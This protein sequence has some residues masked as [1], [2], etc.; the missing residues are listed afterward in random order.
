MLILHAMECFSLEK[1]LI[2]VH[3]SLKNPSD[4]IWLFKNFFQHKMLVVA[5]G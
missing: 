2:E 4:D 1:I 5:F 3:S